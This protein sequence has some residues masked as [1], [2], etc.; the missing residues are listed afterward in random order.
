MLN[1]FHRTVA[2]LA[3]AI[4]VAGSANAGEIALTLTSSDI[5]IS[6]DFVG[7]KDAAYIIRTSSGEL[8]IPAIH[9]SCEGA[10]CLNILTD[11]D[12][13]SG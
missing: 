7:F 8:H 10:D 6:G 11:A 2:V 1:G 4:V 13:V 5:T 12:R 3:S 9:V